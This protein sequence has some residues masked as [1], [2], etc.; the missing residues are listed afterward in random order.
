VL[1]QMISLTDY[2]WLAN[3]M[4][5]QSQHL[6]LAGKY[7]MILLLLTCA[8]WHTHFDLE[9]VLLCHNHIISSGA[10]EKFFTNKD[11]YE[12]ILW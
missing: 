7:D 3:Y 8:G 1:H 11:K 10:L 2:W 5:T 6:L 4:L 9:I 12:S